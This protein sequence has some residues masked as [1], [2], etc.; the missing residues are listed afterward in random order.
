MEKIKNQI[1]IRIEKIDTVKMIDALAAQ[2]AFRSKNEI[3]N[4]AL[5]YGLPLVNATIF[6]KSKIT[7]GENS[8]ELARELAGIKNQIVQQSITVN[9][10]ETL[11]AFLYNVE[12]AKAEGIE[13]TKEFI[14][15]GV[16]ETL[17]EN[18]AEVKREM[19]RIEYEKLRRKND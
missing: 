17:P 16:L 3:L 8:R 12:T 14:E 10:I 19:T 9:V 7:Q 6:G 2:G 1:T 4:R 15:S 18:I 13:I 5:E 11:L